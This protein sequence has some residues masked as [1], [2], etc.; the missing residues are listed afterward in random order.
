MTTVHD[1]PDYKISVIGPAPDSY[2]NKK[3]SDTFSCVP[4]LQDFESRRL[5]FL[6][7]CL[8][9]PAPRNTKAAYYE[10]A[11][12]E[13]GGVIHEGVIFGVLEY[14]NQRKD[15]SDFALHSILRMLY[16]FAD[17]SELSSKLLL[18]ARETVLDFK[19]WPDE[20]GID[21]LCTWTENHQILFASAAYLA[22]QLYP[23]DVFT[24]SGQTGREKMKINAPRIKRWLSLRFRTGF[25]EWLSHVYYDEDMTA[26]LS[27][28][29][30]CSDQEIRQGA[31]MVLD[32]MLLDIVLNSFKGVFGSSHGRSYENTKKWAS[33]EAT[34]DTGKLL[35][36][37]GEF[38]AF[39]SMSA[40]NF[41]LSERYKIPP[42]FF[43]ISNII[44][45]RTI[46]N[47]QRMGIR[48]DEA[49]RWGLGFQQIEDGMIFLSLEAYT[50]NRMVDLFMRMMDEFNWWENG[51]LKPF[52]R[53]R[54][55]LEWLRKFRLLPV[56]TRCLEY[57]VCRNT[58]EEV[59]VY[60]YRTPDYMLSSAQ[61]YRSGYGGDQQHIWQATL[62]PKAVCFTTHP[63]KR[64]DGTP[65]YWTGSGTLPRVAQ[66]NNV[67]IV[68][69]KITKRPSLYVP[70]HYFFTHAWLPRDQF[71][72]VIEKDSWL[73]ARLGNGYL[74]LRSQ[75][76]YT[77]QQGS[78]EDQNRE[79]IADSPENIW[80]CELGCAAD[81]GDFHQ[82]ISDICKASLKFRRLVVT[83]D[84]PSQG[85]LSFGWKDNLTQDGNVI[86]LSDYP[87]YDNPFVHVEFPSNLISV[88]AGNSSLYLE[89]DSLNR[90]MKTRKED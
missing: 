2:P 79:V 23:D 59:N 82:F 5:D 11:R 89:W 38:S 77:W 46:L 83:Y 58:R 29:D 51:F 87:R 62:G 1:S 73:F 88:T 36:G 25:S 57:D 71:D 4:F 86:N 12:L 6:E 16:Q 69:Y 21:D 32:L 60:T 63:S 39:D 67:V 27:L 19:Y 44:H 15:C 22:G 13:A 52:R 85:I 33:N 64:G 78:G 24:N 68:I 90:I 20:T 8:N 61:D 40:V 37:M 35:F 56:L 26:L 14:I 47:R 30:F 49:E 7:H 84:S 28:V 75:H 50:H 74:A 70:N 76:P 48:I 53:Y 80:L 41:A 18:H 45:S 55:L 34:T 66:V 3:I 72:E 31:A 10:L 43:D 65:D 81:N 9:N 42:V 17:R 54:G